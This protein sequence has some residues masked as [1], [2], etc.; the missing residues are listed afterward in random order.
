MT[1][2]DMGK[3][4]SKKDK[5]DPRKTFRTG[6]LIAAALE[7]YNEENEYTDSQTCRMALRRF[8][9]QKYFDEARKLLGDRKAA[10]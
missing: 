8:I 4:V 2:S 6:N 3:T 9:P 10:A 5:D 1:L 7:L